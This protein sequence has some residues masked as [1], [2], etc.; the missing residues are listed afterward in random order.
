M[1]RDLF[2]LFLYHDSDPVLGNTRCALDH[3]A[4]SGSFGFGNRAVLENGTVSSNV[5]DPQCV[6]PVWVTDC[7]GWSCQW[8]MGNV[9]YSNAGVA[10][11]YRGYFY[12]P[13]HRWSDSM[14]CVEGVETSTWIKLLGHSTPKMTRQYCNIYNTDL[15]NN[16]DYLSPWAIIPQLKQKMFIISLNIFFMST[17]KKEG[18]LSP[19]FFLQ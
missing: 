12:V 19:S 9:R 10:G 17:N 14:G 1:R 5:C 7:S 6:D 16:Y 3:G 15:S 8:L 4:D 2:S 13:G 18:D 11:I